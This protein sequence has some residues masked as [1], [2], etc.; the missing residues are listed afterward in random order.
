MS[1][2]GYIAMKES[3]TKKDSK[4]VIYDMKRKKII[5][6]LLSFLFAERGDLIS[7]Q[8][9]STKSTGNNQIYIDLE[10]SSTITGQFNLDPVSY[11]Y[12]LYKITYETVDINGNPHIATGVVSY[13]RVDWPDSPNEAFPIISYQHGTVVERSSVTSESGVWILSAFLSGSGYVY[14]EPDY[15]GLGDSEGMHPYQIKEPYGT[16]IVDLLRAVREYSEGN[17]QFSINEQL[18][19]V[20]YS[21]GGYATMALHQIIERDYSDEFNI[22]AS[23]PMAGAYSM[24]EI[25]VDVMLA[26][27]EYGEPFYFPYVLFSY[28]DSY[29]EIGSMQDYLLPEYWVLEDMFDGYHSSVEINNFMPSVPITIMIPDS[30]TSFANNFNHPLKVALRSNDLWD[31]APEAPMYIFHGIADELVPAENSQ[32]AYDQFIENGADDVFL[33][34]I[35]ATFGGHQDAAPW[36]LLGAFE[37]AQDMQII[38]CL[39]EVDCAGECGGNGQFDDCGV[40]EG[41]NTSCGL[42]GDLNE[43]QVL[44]VLDIVLIV[45]HIFDLYPYNPIADINSDGVVNVLDV[46]GLV[47]LIFEN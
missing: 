8:M 36:A 39:V 18:F 30:V 46:V 34:F 17:N 14:I 5:L 41:D 32:L 2:P 1:F 33:E 13:P 35:P 43:D 12:W 31:W 10:L 45:N 21:E 38:D 23:F 29:P 15:L 44:N 25:M 6:L 3:N 40:C 42:I 20:G 19:L 26:Y 4:G 9:L 28:L 24:S 7:A 11:G 47:N 16:S 37:F 27:Q 22:T